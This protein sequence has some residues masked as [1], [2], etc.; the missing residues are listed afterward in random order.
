MKKLPP[1]EKIYEA[2]SAIADDRVIMREGRAT[3]CSSN[4]AK[5]YIV[6]WAGNVYSSNDNAT[7][8]QGYAGYPVIAVL[9]LQGLLPLDRDI[10]ALFVGINWTEANAAAKR[11][12]A[13]AVETVFA[14]LQCDE[15]KQSAA[16]LENIRVYD[17]L[18]ALNIEITRSAP[19]KPHGSV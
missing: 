15:E 10:A 2:W 16:R 19:R 3:V 13:K 4:R 11:D 12:Y 17:A 1:I 9:M 18:K 8:W 5:E 14:Q 6:S 7:H